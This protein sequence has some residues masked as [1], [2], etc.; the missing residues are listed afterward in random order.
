MSLA[1]ACCSSVILGIKAGA[2][3]TLGSLVHAR[4][5]RAQA[6]MST[7]ETRLI[8]EQTVMEGWYVRKT[9]LSLNHRLA[10]ETTYLSVER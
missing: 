6:F 3:C 10:A 5:R 1:D 9:A 7:R 2:G 4:G 8:Q